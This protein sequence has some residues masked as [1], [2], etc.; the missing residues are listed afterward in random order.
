MNGTKIIFH[1]EPGHKLTIDRINNDGNYEPENCRIADYLTQAGNTRKNVRYTYNGET[2]TVSE[3]ARKLGIERSA[4]SRRVRKW[5]V[6][7]ALT[8]PRCNNR[9]DR[10]ENYLYDVDELK[11]YL[12]AGLSITEISRRMNCNPGITSYR[13]QALRGIDLSKVS[14]KKIHDSI[15]KY[16]EEN[17]LNQKEMA[18]KLGIARVTLHDLLVGYEYRKHLDLRIYD[19]LSNFFNDDFMEDIYGN[20]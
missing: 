15:V 5:G 1:L 11:S 3:W 9:W 18:S 10:K 7:K 17:N 6:E 2:H 14:F 13:V 4:M 8:Q 16:M 19:L 12:D 20:F